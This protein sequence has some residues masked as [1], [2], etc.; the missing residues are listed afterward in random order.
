[1][2][3]GAGRPGRVVLLPGASKWSRYMRGYFTEF[4]S[5]SVSLSKKIR[6]KLV[7]CFFSFNNFNLI[8]MRLERLTYFALFIL[9]KKFKE[10]KVFNDQ[11]LKPMIFT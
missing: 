11:T 9:S 5:K 10:L 8:E 2:A 7:L 4:R 3:G 1:M 6:T